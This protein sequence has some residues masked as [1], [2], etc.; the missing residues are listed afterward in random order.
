MGL[1]TV[2][3]QAQTQ[4]EDSESVV[5]LK[6]RAEIKKLKFFL[7]LPFPSGEIVSKPIHENGTLITPYHEYV[8][9]MTSM[10]MQTF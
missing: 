6:I 5:R 7:T 2:V 8:F 10:L 9:T 3:P 1:T 4:H